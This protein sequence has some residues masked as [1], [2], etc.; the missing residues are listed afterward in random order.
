[1]VLYTETR[2]VAIRRNLIGRVPFDKAIYFC[3]HQQI[4]EVIFVYKQ[5]SLI[6]LEQLFKIKSDRKNQNEISFK[7]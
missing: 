4:L 6:C 3:N 1:M 2:I 5:T 7:E